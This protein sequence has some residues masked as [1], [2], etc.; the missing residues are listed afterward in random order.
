MPINQIP[1]FG[2]Q[3]QQF[4]DADQ[5]IHDKHTNTI[6]SPKSIESYIIGF[7]KTTTRRYFSSRYLM[8]YMSHKKRCSIMKW[9]REIGRQMR[10]CGHPAERQAAAMAPATL[11][12]KGCWIAA[13][14]PS[15]HGY[16][17]LCP[18]VEG[19]GT[20]GLFFCGRLMLQ[21]HGT[22]WIW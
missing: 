17:S 11:G 10:H 6:K 1:R 12:F 2:S 21:K 3:N 15:D 19:S 8:P 14:K 4:P 7:A 20:L 13:A 5:T 9:D 16:V 18:Y 22:L